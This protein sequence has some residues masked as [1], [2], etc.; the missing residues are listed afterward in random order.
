MRKIALR[1]FSLI[2]A[3]ALL[4]QMH[5]QSNRRI[6]TGISAIYEC[7][8]LGTTKS[9]DAAPEKF[10]WDL[11]QGIYF[12][13]IGTRS[14]D[15]KNY[16]II[17]IFDYK[18]RFKIERSRFNLKFQD[19]DDKV[20]LG[21]ELYEGSGKGT[22][23]ME[24]SDLVIKRQELKLKLR[25]NLVKYKF[26]LI[27]EE[28]FMSKSERTDGCNCGSLTGGALTIPIKLRLDN[29]LRVNDF[30]KDITI[31]GVAG[32]RFNC[33]HC[34]KLDI[35]PYVGLGITSISL[36]STNTFGSVT[37]SSDRSGVTAVIG[38]MFEND[39]GLQVGLSGGWDH[40]ATKEGIDWVNNG[41]FWFGFGV[42]YALF[43]EPS[44]PGT[45]EASAKRN[46]GKKLKL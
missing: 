2:C 31:G 14:I 25:N 28:D 30:S 4:N 27:A 33:P 13:S 42:G 37:N 7:D 43:S 40:L 19:D 32:W 8:I 15:G 45:G 21:K 23:Q 39:K 44:A 12:D 18:N 3:L 41:N 10:E 1:L 35:I 16:I 34:E 5:G 26:F 38:I 22:F 11:E 36:D 46:K 6:S 9:G 20:F 29:S 17:S 24:E